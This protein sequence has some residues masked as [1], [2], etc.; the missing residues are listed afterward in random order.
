[1][2]EVCVDIVK[3]NGQKCGECAKDEVELKSCK[4]VWIK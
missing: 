2:E 4:S 3:L 1:L